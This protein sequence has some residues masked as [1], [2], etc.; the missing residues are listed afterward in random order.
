MWPKN[1]ETFIPINA[2]SLYFGA[3]VQM[4]NDNISRY[5]FYIFTLFN[6]L[7]D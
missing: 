5:I 6:L 7:K 4:T 2:V 3:E 1:V